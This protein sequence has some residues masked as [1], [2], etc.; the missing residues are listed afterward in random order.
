MRLILTGSNQHL[1]LFCVAFDNFV[2]TVCICEQI[3]VPCNE[4]EKGGFSLPCEPGFVELGEL[5]QTYPYGFSGQAYNIV[6][7][8]RIFRVSDSNQQIKENVTIDKLCLI[9]LKL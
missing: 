9:R 6:F 8:V 1:N 4:D 2:T 3:A 7:S 5:C